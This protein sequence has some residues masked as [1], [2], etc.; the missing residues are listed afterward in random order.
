MRPDPRTNGGI[1][2]LVSDVSDEETEGVPDAEWRNA[3]IAAYAETKG[4][5][6]GGATRKDEML[7]AIEENRN[8]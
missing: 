8:E 3:E 1:E 6:L 5:D 4:I 7:K 2:A